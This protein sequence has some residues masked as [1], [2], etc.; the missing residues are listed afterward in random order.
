MHSWQLWMQYWW[1]WMLAQC[2]VPENM[3]VSRPVIRPSNPTAGHTHRGNQNWKRHVYPMFIVAIARTWEQPRCPSADKW[4]RKLW[5]IYT[6]EYY[7]AIKNSAFE[8]VLV[9]WMKLESIKQSDGKTSA[10][11]AGDPGLTPGLGRFPGEGNGNPLQWFCPENSMD[12]G[13]W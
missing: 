2:A 8:S 3:W 7:S 13:V 11:N 9:R 1:R 6:M 5:F 10:C 4:V 12:W